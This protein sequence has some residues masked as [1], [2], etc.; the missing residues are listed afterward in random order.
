MELGELTALWKRAPVA[1]RFPALLDRLTH[2]CHIVEFQGDCYR[3]KESLLQEG[4]S[5][6][7]DQALVVA[8]SIIARVGVFSIITVGGFSLD[9]HNYSPRRVPTLS[10]PFSGRALRGAS[11]RPA[12]P[13]G[14]SPYLI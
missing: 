8:F 4:E 11:H 5:P 10:P 3:A 14:P 2:R 7:L 9:I 6:L 12:W 1:I 13:F